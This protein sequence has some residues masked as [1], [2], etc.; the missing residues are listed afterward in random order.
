ML[1]PRG[2]MP[3]DE[4]I[5]QRLYGGRGPAEFV[6][7]QRLG[8][9]WARELLAGTGLDETGLAAALGAPGRS[10][11]KIFDDYCY[12]RFTRSEPL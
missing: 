12:V 3:W 4:A 8:R 7:H 1:R 10:L 11:S 6:A 5:A 9:S 2:L